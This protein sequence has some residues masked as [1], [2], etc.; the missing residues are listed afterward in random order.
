MALRPAAPEPFLAAAVEIG[1]TICREA[2]WD[3]PGCVCNWM[4]RSYL[5]TAPTDGPWTPRSAALGPDLYGGSPGVA[6][7]LAQ[8]GS[9]TGDPDFRR[10]AVAAAACALRQLERSPRAADSPISYYSGLLG[11]AWALDRIAALTGVATLAERVDE[12]LAQVADGA[13]APHVLDVI[14]GNAGAIPAL[15]A[16]S[17]NGAPP[18]AR[19]LAERLG[20]ELLATAIRA[21]PV[22]TWEAAQVAGPEIGTI[23]LAG[24]AHG[25]AG[26]GA[27]LFELYAATGRR[28]FRDGG[29][30]A[31]AYEDSLF[32]AAAGNWRDP[33]SRGPEDT[34]IRQFPVAWCHGAPGI[35][36]ARMRAAALDPELAERYRSDARIALATT[37]AKLADLLARERHDATLCHGAGGLSEV[38]WTGGQWL[39]DESLADAARAAGRALIDKY[40]ASGSWPSGVVLAGPNPSLMVGNAGIGLHFLRLHA[41][42]TVPPLLIVTG[43]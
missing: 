12:L 26:L 21:G 5:G 2:V 6:W 20:E 43:S 29:R 4:G 14:G 18:G 39:G 13:A 38:V 37:R 23:P 8:V 42:E 35:A 9:L 1:R 31:L 24:L 15:L 22:W 11:T 28:D 32:D 40:A 25:S 41:P 36:L 27:A 19:A 10:T 3:A 16:L 7:F 17:R 30:G 34:Q 33:R